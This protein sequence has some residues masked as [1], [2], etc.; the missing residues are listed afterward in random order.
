MKTKSIIIGI[1][2]V[3]SVFSAVW[4]GKTS[5]S[6]LPANQENK[7]ISKNG[8]HWHAELKIFVK[9]KEIE[10][11]ANIG[12][13][14]I[15]NP[16]H[17]HDTDGIIHMEFNRIVRENDLKLGK[18]FEVWRKKFDSN[19]GKIKMLVNGKENNEFED[20]AMRDGDKI[21]IRYE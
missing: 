8:I 18:F 3:V 11:P 19:E 12:I 17:T 1:V 10:V 20:Y 14:V 2:L 5:K 16:L 4:Y 15:H 13:G 7:I 21:E 6:N 9:G